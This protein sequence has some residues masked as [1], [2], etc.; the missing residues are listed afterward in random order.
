MVRRIK[1]TSKGCSSCGDRVTAFGQIGRRIRTKGN[2]SWDRVI[3][4]K[5]TGKGCGS[6]GDEVTGCGQRY[7]GYQQRLFS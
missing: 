1:C 5:G 6:S 2:C 4:M 3:G 7:E